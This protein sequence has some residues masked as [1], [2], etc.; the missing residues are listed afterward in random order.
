MFDGH[1]NPWF[2]VCRLLLF[3]CAAPYGKKGLSPGKGLVHL[4]SGGCTRVAETDSPQ[5]WDWL[6]GVVQRGSSIYLSLCATRQARPLPIASYSRFHAEKNKLLLVSYHCSINYV[7]PG[8]WRSF[9]PRGNCS[10]HNPGQAGSDGQEQN[11]GDC[12][13]E[14]GEGNTR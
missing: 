10:E 13:V 14:R 3:A 9:V 4:G 5:R 7:P 11:I 8:V 1:P 6:V 2:H 12:S